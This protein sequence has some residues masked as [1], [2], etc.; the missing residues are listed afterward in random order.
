MLTE[1][2]IKNFKCFKDEIIIPA[3]RIN[4][5]T[6]LNGRGKSTSLQPL[7]CMKQSFERLTRDRLFF[8]WNCVELGNFGD[9]KNVSTRRDEDIIFAFEFTRES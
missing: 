4:L 2:R 8:N 3:G 1:I 5:L 7:L 6:G 9:V